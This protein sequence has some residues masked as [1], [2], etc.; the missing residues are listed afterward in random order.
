[1]SSRR[2]ALAAALLAPALGCVRAPPPDLSAD[3][4]EL[5]S[6]VRAREA[7]VLRVTGSARVRLE[8]PES[9]GSLEALAAA[10]RPDRLRLELLDFFGGPVALLV[11]AEGRFAF[12]DAR[13][14]TWYRGAATPENLSRIVRVPLSAEDLAAAACGSPVLVPGRPRA[15]EPGD[16]VMRLWLE[17]GDGLAQ[18]LEVGEGA[19]VESSRRWRRSGGGDRPDGPALDFGSFRRVGGLRF[20]GAVRVEAGG[21]SAELRWK[22][23]LA[24][25]GPPD[26]A[27]FAVAIPPGARVVDLAPGAEPPPLVLPG[28]GE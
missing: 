8:S 1:L 18:R 27:L 24:V 23:D 20:P 26:P 19:A 2:A 15:A 13:R 21:R 16:G 14:A 10:E 7:R 28:P 17:A 12:L 9:S 5:L 11:V 6:A 3:P 25:N 22:G 4:A